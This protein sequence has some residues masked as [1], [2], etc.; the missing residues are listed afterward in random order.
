MLHSALLLH[1]KPVAEDLDSSHEDLLLPDLQRRGG[2]AYDWHPV[3]KTL[4]IRHDVARDV[5]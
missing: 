1:Q 5:Q 2:R 4:F 3:A